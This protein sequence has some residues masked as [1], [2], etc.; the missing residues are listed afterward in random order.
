M[1]SSR[2][3]TRFNEVVQFDLVFIE[4][5]VV[6]HLIDEATKWSVCDVLDNRETS[7]V[8]AFINNHWLRTFG[9]IT[10]IISDQ[11]GAIYS[12]EGGIWAEKKGI[13]LRPKPKG[14]HAAIVERHHQMIRELMH[15]LLH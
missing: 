10:T 14:A 15:R 8:L 11:E 6:G 7:T 4:D 9:P 12:E 1:A 3:S 2:L 5:K 13:Q